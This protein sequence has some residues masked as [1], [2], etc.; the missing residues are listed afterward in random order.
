MKMM[1]IL[2]SV[3]LAVQAQTPAAKPFDLTIDNIMRGSAVYGYAP[4]ALRWQPDGKRLFFDWKEYT[5]PIEKDFDTWVV[6]RDGKN[7]RRLSDEEK[8]DATPT[9]ARWT[10]DHKRALFADEGDI[11]LYD[12]A[13]RRNLTRTTDNESSPR[14]TRDER[15]VAFVRGNNLFVMALDDGS[16]VQMTNIAGADEKGPNVDL[17]NDKDKSK[18]ASQLWVEKEERKLIDT[19]DRRAKKREADEAKKKRENPRKPLK[20]EGKQSVADLELAPDEKSVFAFLRTEG[21]KTKR[22]IVPNYVTESAYTE[23]IPGR[24][25]VGDDEPAT[26]L[27]RIDTAT[28]ESKPVDFGL[29]LAPDSGRDNAKSG[30]TT[31]TTATPQDKKPEATQGQDKSGETKGEAA[32]AK[33]REVGIEDLLWSDDGSKGVAVIR[34]NDNK[35]RWIVAVDPA[36]GKTRV[37]VTMHDDAWV[38]YRFTEAGW[39]KDSASVWYLSEQSGWGHLYTV[40]WVGGTP[41]GTP[42]ALTEGKWEVGAAALSDDGK[43][44]ELTTSE[45]SLHE[46][47]FWRLP[48]AGVARVRVTSDPGF[49]D[50]VGSPDGGM[51]ADIYSYTNKPPELYLQ[52]MQAGAARTRV[53]TSPSPEFRAA[54]WLDVPI[55]N[56]PARDGT[57]VPAR[58]YKPPSPNGAAV[59]FVHGA[60]Y[61]QNVHRGWSSYEHEYLFHHFLMAHGYTVLDVDYRGSSGY[62]RDWRT[63]I[64]RHMGGTD[65]DDQLDAAKW[66]VSHEGID[67]RRIGVYGGSYGG[68]ITL[69]AMF[70]KPGTFAAGAAL[71]PVTDWAAYNAGYTS[72]ILNNPQSDPEAYR[73]SSPIYFA[74]G[75]QGALL[76]CHGVVDVNVHFQDTVRLAQRLIELRKEN[77]DVAF[78]PMESHGFVEA[79]SWADEYKRIY[80]LFERNLAAR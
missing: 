20:L 37:L 51:L 6:D 7:L 2:L 50:A 73:Q 74:E 70:T 76:I 26:K 80:K 16:L 68:F 59:V 32:Q 55:V 4:R 66:L 29:P 58:F 43:W 21:G 44:F 38:N 71:R 9:D 8:K 49:H 1:A 14:W 17:W 48:V 75:L 35:D 69:M 72:N 36:N 30:A 45:T 28:G 54:S 15:H 63:A 19:V 78:Y 41:G 18:S 40:P 61:L 13:K 46:H 31:P 64:Y 79:T 47:H 42:K 10:R 77:W 56:I 65:L 22:T 27:L 33:A 23:T 11:F 3:S 60:G 62:G 57:Q 67:A 24:T 12:G 34:S 25:K 52:P 5:E 39:L 53:T